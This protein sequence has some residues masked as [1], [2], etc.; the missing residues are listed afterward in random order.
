MLKNLLK[1]QAFT[2]CIRPF[3]NT[4]PGFSG[5]SANQNYQTQGHQV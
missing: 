1:R 4:Q 2:P 5:K 3:L